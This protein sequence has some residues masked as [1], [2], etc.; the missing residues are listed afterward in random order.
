MTRRSFAI[1]PACGASRRMGTN[2]LLLPWQDAT[3]LETVL[4]AWQASKVDSV[5]LVTP[6]DRREVIEL[7]EAS[8]ARV[9]VV[10]E[11][12]PDMKG[13]VLAGLRWIEQNLEVG[14]D[15]VWLVAP[16]DMPDLDPRTIDTVLAASEANPGKVVVPISGGQ[17]GHP[18]LFPWSLIPAVENLGPEQGLRDLPD[19]SESV[20]VE[21]NEGGLGS[22][23]DDPEEYLKRRQGF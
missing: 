16:A 11:A 23:I 21:V 22:D 9:A 1:V 19:W 17:H 18:A 20:S 7:A 13:T 12:P 5:V 4:K 8:G 2:K 15:D 10:T 6:A 14:P 3:I